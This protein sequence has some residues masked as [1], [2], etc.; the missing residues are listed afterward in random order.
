MM[1]SKLSDVIDLIGGG[2]PETSVA[3]YWGG[4]I[5]KRLGAIGYEI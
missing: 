4:E 5:R 2:T 3:E 1:T